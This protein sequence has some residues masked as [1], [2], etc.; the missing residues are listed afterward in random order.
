MSQFQQRS[1][2]NVKYTETKLIG[3]VALRSASGA[4]WGWSKL[5]KR[6]HIFWLLY[7]PQWNHQTKPW[8]YCAAI[9]SDLQYTMHEEIPLRSQ[10]LRFHTVRFLPGFVLAEIP[11]SLRF[12]QSPFTACVS[13]PTSR[14]RLEKVRRNACL[15][16]WL[17]IM[18]LSKC[19]IDFGLECDGSAEPVAGWVCGTCYNPA[20]I[21]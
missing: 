11:S 21:S 6:S 19:K 10:T 17:L 20:C 18:C 13:S 4:L 1:C 15:S 5:C 7:C 2:Y 12:S 9:Q 16:T 14:H 3:N 8:I